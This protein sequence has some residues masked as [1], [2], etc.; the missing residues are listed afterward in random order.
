MRKS[1]KS[2][3]ILIQKPGSHEI[4]LG[5]WVFNQ[6]FDFALSETAMIDITRDI[7]C[8]HSISA[9]MRASQA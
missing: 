5:S 6:I 4:F 7:N 1:S 8:G 9:I 3:R 2:R